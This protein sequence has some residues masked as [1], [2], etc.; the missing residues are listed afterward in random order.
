M[1]I[2]KGTS[3]LNDLLEIKSQRPTRKTKPTSKEFEL[4][5]KQR[6]IRPNQILFGTFMQSRNGIISM[7]NCTKFLKSSKMDTQATE[8]LSIP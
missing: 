7:K 2:Y 6:N 1:F 8:E 4:T 5:N 3:R